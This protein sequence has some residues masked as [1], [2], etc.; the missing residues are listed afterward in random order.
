MQSCSH[1]SLKIEFRGSGLVSHR[2][3]KSVGC[4]AFALSPWLASKKRV[5]RKF[6][7]T[8]SPTTTW[9]VSTRGCGERENEM[10]VWLCLRRGDVAGH[11]AV[12]SW[13]QQKLAEQHFWEFTEFFP[14]RQDPFEG[15]R[16]KEKSWRPLPRV[17]LIWLSEP[18]LDTRWGWLCPSWFLIIIDEQQL[19]GPQRRILRERGQ[20]WRS[21]D[22]GDAHSTN[23]THSLW[24]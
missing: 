10:L 22:D 13:C 14:P 7:L 9:I 16:K 18:M 12:S 8:W 5:C 23:L 15:C 1:L 2:P 6:P 20:P 3:R 17:R 21:H 24:R 11:Q 4:W 19:C